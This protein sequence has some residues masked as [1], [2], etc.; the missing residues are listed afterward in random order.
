MWAIGHAGRATT[1][2]DLVLDEA[3]VLGIVLLA[4]LLVIWH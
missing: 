1:A 3:L 4:A 2:P